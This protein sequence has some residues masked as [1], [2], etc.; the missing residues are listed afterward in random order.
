MPTIWT[1][2]LIRFSVPASRKP[3]RK[4]DL[5]YIDAAHDLWPAPRSFLIRGDALGAGIMGLDHIARSPAAGDPWQLLRSD[6]DAAVGPAE[7]L[8]ETQT[9]RNDGK[10]GPSNDLTAATCIQAKKG[11]TLRRDQT[12]A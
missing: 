11:M 6:R 2:H 4:V 12:Y 1:Q 9:G 5:A 3:T 10:L 8:P 7:V